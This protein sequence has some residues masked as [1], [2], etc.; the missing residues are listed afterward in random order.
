[1]VLIG[2]VCLYKLENKQLDILE[3]KKYYRIWIGVKIVEV[4]NLIT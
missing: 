4:A 3:V 2:S 1:V